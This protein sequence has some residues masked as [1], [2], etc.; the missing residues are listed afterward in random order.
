MKR[1]KNIKIVTPTQILDNDII[2]NSKGVIEA[3]LN[4]LT[5]L[6]KSMETIDGE[7]NFAFP[8]MIDILT[9]GYGQHLY[10]DADKNCIIENSQALLKHG[11]TSFVPSILSNKLP[12]HLNTLS[13]LSSIL[14][15]KGARVLGLHSEGPCF[16]K[17]GAHDF[18]NLI[19]PSEVL[20]YQ[21]LE[22]SNGKLKFITMAP[23]LP[24]ATAFIKI[25]K[26]AGV[27]IHIGHSN[28]QPEQV[29][30][31]VEMGVTAAT[32]VYNVCP[33]PENPNNGLTPLS[34][35]D[36][37]IAEPNICLG[38][39]CDGAHVHPTHVKLLSQLPSN[40]FFLETDSMK[41]SGIGL[42]KFELYPGKWV[43]S[44]DND[45]ARMDNGHLAGST[46]TCDR[47]LKNL[48]KFTRLS[49][50]EASIATSLNPARL[51]GEDAKIGSIEIGKLA[52][53][54]LLNPLTFDIMATYISGKEKYNKQNQFLEIQKC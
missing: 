3:F 42:G 13:K 30:S 20:A 35:I 7:G 19:L 45:A 53:I 6:S 17:A 8:G 23:E 10:G 34:L 50:S 11:V 18:K 24:G 9:H 33:Y 12:N 5:P 15:S 25:L 14:N 54:V 51:A 4:A 41:Y 2:I 32:H 21:L 46:L 39:I 44:N 40:R 52:D 28:A 22:A 27:G 29:S 26:N 1:L 36:A 48:L 47:A 16:A 31:F 38:I 43:T 37:L 49:L